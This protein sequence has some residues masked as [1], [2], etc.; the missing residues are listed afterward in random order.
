ML[1]LRFVY[2]VWQKPVIKHI[3]ME[4]IVFSSERIT[5]SIQGATVTFL[6]RDATQ[7]A[8]IPQ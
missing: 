1:K 5:N 3:Q 7:S 2:L 8:V 6:P 4:I